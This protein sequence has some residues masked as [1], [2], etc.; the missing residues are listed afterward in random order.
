MHN[1]VR[2]TELDELSREAAGHYHAPGTPDWEK[3]S[4]ELDKVLPREKRKKRP[5]AWWW[6][7][8][9]LVA[10]V[11]GYTWFS[12]NDTTPAGGQPSA[13]AVP[14]AVPSPKPSQPV[15]TQQAAPEKNTAA[16]QGN[17]SLHNDHA[18]GPDKLPG[19]TGNTSA[20]KNIR[21]T[22]IPAASS[23]N[24]T[25]AGTATVVTKEGVRK[26]EATSTNNH[27][28]TEQAG[29]AVKTDIPATQ[30]NNTGTQPFTQQPVAS[31]PA[32]K[33]STA[34]ANEQSATTAENSAA[35]RV[36][37]RRPGKGFSVGIVA[38]TDISTVK[39]RYGNTPGLN[40]GLLAGYH[41]SNTWSLHT[42]LI[43]TQKNYKLAGQDFHAPKGSWASYYKILTVEGD[44]RMWEL[45][46]LARYTFAP[47]K[48]TRNQYFISTG[49]SSY[50]MKRENYEYYYYYQNNPA[51]RNASY[52][53][54]N[55]HVLSI[56]HLSAGM[57]KKLSKTLSLQVEP[58]AKIPLAGVGVGQIR[59][60]SFGVNF[61]LQF[62]QPHR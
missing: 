32:I 62:R 61:G 14:S 17:T 22:G 26:N 42:G 25:Q 30:N 38:G 39:F 4:R 31:S 46:L 15:T 28:V 34:T 13:Q 11:I 54:G 9:L 33:D 23:I 58:Y 44:C 24:N 60:S 12:G 40:I 8:P 3:M 6:L 36:T 50:F 53:S 55:T 37:V 57:E 56:V 21:S 43:Y 49:L 19:I 48:T 20:Q 41:F 52:P 47:G 1:P 18:S 27:S 16:A 2:D 59:L 7:F 29:T 5:A 10:G 45:P 51:T 35:T